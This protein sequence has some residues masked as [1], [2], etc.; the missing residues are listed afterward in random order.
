MI[1]IDAGTATLPFM[2]RIALIE[3]AVAARR[4]PRDARRAGDG[5]GR[6]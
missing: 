5:L 3:A 6:R 2:N 1:A 4:P